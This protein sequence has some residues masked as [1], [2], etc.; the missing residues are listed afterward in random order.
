MTRKITDKYAAPNAFVSAPQGTICR[1][2]DDSGDT[3]LYI[4]LGKEEQIPRWATLGQFFEV[5]FENFV[6]NDEFIQDCMKIYQYKELH[7]FH[8]IAKKIKQSPS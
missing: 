7:A 8:N 5:A 6:D 3:Q 4:Q 2:F 1:V